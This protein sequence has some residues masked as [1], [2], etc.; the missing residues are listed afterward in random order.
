MKHLKS[1]NYL[2]HHHESLSRAFFQ[3][4]YIQ[5][6]I[7]LVFKKKKRKKNL[8]APGPCDVQDVY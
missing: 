2:L 4:I 7:M 1:L 8:K 3:Y 5:K 6:H